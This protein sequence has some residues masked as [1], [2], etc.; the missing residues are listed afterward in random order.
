MS[1]FILFYFILFYLS[2]L[3]GAGDMGEELNLFVIWIFLLVC[4]ISYIVI[5]IGHRHHR[6]YFTTTILRSVEGGS[7]AALFVCWD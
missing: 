5:V 2:S 3:G 4:Y 7:G 1:R 6:Y